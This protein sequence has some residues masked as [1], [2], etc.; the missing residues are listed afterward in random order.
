MTFLF[1]E[2]SFG[3]PIDSIEQTAPRAAMGDYTIEGKK[4]RI[5]SI[6]PV[7][8]EADRIQVLL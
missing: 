7:R 2:L 4:R 1:I 3:E 8:H 5:V 6:R